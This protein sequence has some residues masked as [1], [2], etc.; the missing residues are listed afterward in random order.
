[1]SARPGPLSRTKKAKGASAVK[2]EGQSAKAKAQSTKSPKATKL[3]FDGVE[4]PKSAAANAFDSISQN[5]DA[6]DGDAEGE[7]DGE[8]EEEE[9][10]APQEEQSGEE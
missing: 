1:M 3:V 5:G 7:E 2:T 9:E 8:G 4:I 6:E 10:Q